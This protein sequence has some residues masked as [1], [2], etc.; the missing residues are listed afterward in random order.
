MTR[1]MVNICDKTTGL[2]VGVPCPRV[3]ERSAQRIS[4][5]FGIF[6]PVLDGDED[7]PSLDEAL[8]QTTPQLR[9]F[10]GAGHA[11]FWL[12][13]AV[14]MHPDDVQKLIGSD[15]VSNILATGKF[16]GAPEPVSEAANTQ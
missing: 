13:H 7:L 9:H 10:C 11:N 4:L 8:D 15:E 3:V 16:Q 5:I 6:G 2:K 12:H 14:V 1:Q